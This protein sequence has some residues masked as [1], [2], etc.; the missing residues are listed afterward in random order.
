MVCYPLND[1]CVH[2]VR[3]MSHKVFYRASFRDIRLSNE[4]YHCHHG[5]SAYTEETK[6][7]LATMSSLTTTKYF[8]EVAGPHKM[9]LQRHFTTTRPQSL[10]PRETL[11][12]QKTQKIA[13]L[14]LSKLTML[15]AI[16]S[17]RSLDE[18]LSS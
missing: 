6:A 14:D 17:Y 8:K 11:T 10:E 2:R 7:Q 4:S 1:C 18:L 5:K 9:G 13:T 3:E 15:M 12:T 16:D